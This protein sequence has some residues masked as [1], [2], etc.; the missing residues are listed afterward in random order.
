M[1]GSSENQRP[2]LQSGSQQLVT[3]TLPP[4]EGGWKLR[5]SEGGQASLS[6]EA[7]G[8]PS[9][10]TRRSK[11]VDGRFRGSN[12]TGRRGEIR[13]H[14]TGK[15]EERDSGRGLRVWASGFGLRPASG[16]GLGLNWA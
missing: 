3:A 6:E 12:R 14:P 8:G 4:R 10:E 9:I 1:S 2:Y 15:K 13:V 16:P 11:Q 7:S 5:S